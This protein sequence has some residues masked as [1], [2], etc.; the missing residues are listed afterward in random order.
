MT[1]KE[2]IKVRKSVRTYT[3]EPFGNQNASALEEYIKTL[4]GPF[5]GEECTRIALLSPGGGVDPT[6]FATYG[7]IKGAKRY[8]ALIIDTRKGLKAEL[9]GGYMMEHVVLWATTRGWGT[10]WLGGTFHCNRFEKVLNLRDY[11]KVVAVSPVGYEADK[12]RLVERMFRRVAGSDHRKPFN[13]LFFLN[14]F[15]TPYPQNGPL[16]DAFKAVRLAPSAT[17][18]QPWRILVQNNETYFYAAPDPK[19]RN[20]DIGIAMAHFD[21]ERGV[22]S[23]WSIEGQ[24]PAAQWPCLVRAIDIQN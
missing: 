17:N 11:E 6:T 2:A 13:D 12:P 8:F 16:A 19:F 5:P 7:V 14:N 10:C 4:T 1:L 23:Q 15:S 9:A 18:K 21:I 3:G 20:N 24:A 22:V